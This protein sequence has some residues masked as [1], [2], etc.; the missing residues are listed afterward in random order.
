[1]ALAP[2]NL[3]DEEDS[4]DTRQLSFK[5]KVSEQLCHGDAVY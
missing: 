5:Q 2:V 4:Y 3:Q 1:M